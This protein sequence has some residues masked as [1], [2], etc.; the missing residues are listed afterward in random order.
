VFGL[1]AFPQQLQKLET[2]NPALLSDVLAVMLPRDRVRRIVFLRRRDRVAQ[3]VS[4]ARATMSG[5]WRK[6]QESA[7]TPLPEYS[8]EQLESAERGIAFQEGVWEQM[9]EELRIEPLRLWHEDALADPATVSRQVADYLE[10]VIDPDA[11]V[12]VPPIEKQT[13]GDSAEWI[14]RYARSREAQ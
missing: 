7:A 2:G 14:E 13:E 9:F 3:T 10:V 8:P 1:K 11:A 5:V 12:H 4:Y 6:E